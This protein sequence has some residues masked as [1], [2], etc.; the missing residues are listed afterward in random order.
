MA[1]KLF[2]HACR[3]KKDLSHEEV[4]IHMFD[5]DIEHF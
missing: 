3:N 5:Q 2:D 1:L 4:H